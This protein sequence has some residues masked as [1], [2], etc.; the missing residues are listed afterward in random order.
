MQHWFEITN[1]DEV[2]SPALLFYPERIQQNIGR[3][4]A[5][6]GSADRLRPH[7]KTYKCREV[8]NMQMEAGISKFKCATLAEAEMVAR[9][10]V[11]DVLL[12]Y[13]LVGPNKKR[14]IQLTAQYP[15][16]RFS[17]LVDHEEQ[18][19]GWKSLVGTEGTVQV[20]IDLDAGMHRTGTIPEL[21]DSLVSQL[22]DP[23]FIF[24]GWHCYDGH[25]HQTD[26][27]ERQVAVDQQYKSILDL[28]N[29]HGLEDKEFICGSSISFPIHAQHPER[30]LSPG[31]TLLWD[32]GYST[33]FPDLH[34]DVAAMLLARVVT[35][36]GKDLL[37]IDLGYKA[38]ASEMKEAPVFFPQL[39]D[40][41]IQT[42][43]EEHLVI[44]TNK[45]EKWTI[46]DVVY[47]IPW[48][49]CPT[50]ALYDEA[51]IVHHR[52]VNDYWSIEARIRH[53]RINES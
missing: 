13:P 42:H 8:V 43:S 49:I 40:A 6:A 25:I 36:P 34:F 10:G 22:D 46:G 29:R 11:K 33:K 47:G 18:I 45:A 52:L 37:C 30:T 17:V 3:M 50:V 53:H 24:R 16:I 41:E 38:V 23:A 4:I 48:H 19:A 2:L 21:A 15:E 20:F 26:F 7:V 5:I 51:A 35:K 32:H 39:P 44:K 1:T 14:F 12:A 27:A 31:T 28:V 9:C